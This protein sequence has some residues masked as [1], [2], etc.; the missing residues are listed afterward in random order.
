MVLDRVHGPTMLES[1]FAGTTTIEDAARILAELHR[2]LHAITP[3]PE[4]EADGVI[5]HL[6]LHPENIIESPAGPVL[7]DWRNSDV[8]PAGVDVALTGLVIAQVAVSPIVEAPAAR[9]LLDA[10]LRHVGP[11]DPS[12]VHEATAYRSADP[13]MAPGELD[14]LS[15]AKDLLL[16]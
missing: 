14:L 15:I 11:L 1:L 10:Y 9:D 13:N 8:G 16:R 2:Q 4:Q 12:D 6:D 7:I 5:C 3:P